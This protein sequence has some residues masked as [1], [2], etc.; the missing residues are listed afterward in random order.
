MNCSLPEPAQRS[1]ADIV[2]YDPTVQQTLGV[3]FHHMAVD[4]SAY[5]GEVIDGR[6]ELVMSRGKPVVERGRYV[7]RVGHGQYVKRGLSQYLV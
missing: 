3:E 6:C 7:G 4:Y 2:I 5:E 1:N